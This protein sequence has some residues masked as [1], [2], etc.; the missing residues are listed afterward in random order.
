MRAER[1][2]GRWFAGLILLG[3]LTAMSPLALAEQDVVVQART[4][5]Y[6]GKQNRGQALALLKQHLAQQS[7]DTE[8]QVLY[9]IVLSWE[10]RYD[11]S[12]E[13]LAHVLEKRPNHGDALSALI[14]VELWSDHPDRAQQLATLGLAQRPDDIRLLLFQARALRNMNR[15]R[16][17]LRVLDRVLILE[18]GNAEAK[19][20][21]RTLATSGNWETSLSH[22]YAWFSDGR[23]PQHE[24]AFSLRGTTPVG[25]LTGTISRADRF[26]LVSYQTELDFYP[27]FRSGTYGY[28]NIGYSADGNLYPTYRLGG[29]IFQSLGKGFEVS[30]GYR[31][32]S[33][34][35]GINIYTFALAKYH[36]SWLFTTRAFLT[37]GQPGTSRTGVFSARRFFGAEGRHDYIEVRYSRGVSPA[38]ARTLG[39]IQS[40][41]SSRFSAEFDKFLGGRWFANVGGGIGREQRVGLSDLNRYTFQGSV[42]YR[43]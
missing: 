17:A 8:A 23:D 39:D 2:Y 29:D 36:G 10:G 21:R 11:E 19:R 9:G 24:T 28:L 7:D 42:Y 16:E 37:P 12:R 43:F 6:S 26:S 27:H 20:M 1:N 40:L 30:G 18:P 3:V 13:Q 15:S 14:N 5:A 35:S 32:L 34:S 38:L 41:D 31:H 22:N 4:L 33:F 25:S